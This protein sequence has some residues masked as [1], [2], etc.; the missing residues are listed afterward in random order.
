MDSATT[1]RNLSI[2]TCNTCSAIEYLRRTEKKTSRIKISTR[3]SNENTIESIPQSDLDLGCFRAEIRLV[4]GFEHARIASD[5]LVADCSRHAPGRRLGYGW[6]RRAR[7]SAA[8][9]VRHDTADV[10]RD[11]GRI[12]SVFVCRRL[13]VVSQKPLDS[14]KKTVD[15][16]IK[17]TQRSGCQSV[18]HSYRLA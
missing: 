3:I 18:L 4:T 11:T 5:R 2:Q 8:P 13:N 1:L 7:R 9:G 6:K 17:N 15:V 10:G 14:I 16:K 12:A